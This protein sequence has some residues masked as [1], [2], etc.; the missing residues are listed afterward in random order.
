MSVNN[1]HS[2]LLSRSYLFFHLKISLR[3]NV[4]RSEISLLR[5]APTRAC[6]SRFRERIGRRIGERLFLRREYYASGIVSLLHN[7]PCG[8]S[9]ENL[10]SARR[11]SGRS[12]NTRFIDFE[13]RC[14][15]AFV[16]RPITIGRRECRPQAVFG[17]KA[18][19]PVHVDR[20]SVS[21]GP[22]MDSCAI[23]RARFVFSTKMAT[24]LARSRAQRPL[25]SRSRLNRWFSRVSPRVEITT[26]T[27]VDGD[28]NVPRALYPDL[29]N[30]GRRVSPLSINADLISRCPRCVYAAI[31]AAEAVQS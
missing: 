12:I 13:T 22:K 15:P 24:S 30:E 11:V 28:L 26:V 17:V 21:R 10:P 3:S 29:F 4:L 16:T 27:R 5:A 19:V 6:I 2:F 23:E 8:R 14:F 20:S 9:D 31:E 18:K 25:V 7:E 1:R